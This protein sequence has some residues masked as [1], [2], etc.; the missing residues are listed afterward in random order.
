MKSLARVRKRNGRCYELAFRVML[1]EPGADGF[2]LIHGR[3][4]PAMI[5]HAWIDLNDGRVYDPVRD[6]YVQGEGYAAFMGGAVV[7]QRY[8]KH[9][10]MQASL[11]ARHY[12]PWV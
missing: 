1:D 12:G 4:G 6:S 5:G 3:V 11:D 2:T 9:E 8:T 7:E 10:A